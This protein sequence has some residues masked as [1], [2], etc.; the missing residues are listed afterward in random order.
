MSREKAIVFVS[1]L[2][3][4][5]QIICNGIV[6]NL[7]KD[8]DEVILPVTSKTLCSIERMYR[9]LNVTC[10]DGNTDNNVFSIIDKL[11]SEGYNFLKIGM[12]GDR[13]MVDDTPFS[14]S[15][16]DQAGIPFSESFDSFHLIRNAKEEEAL[17]NYYKPSDKYAFLHQD[18]PRGLEV[19][20]DKH[21]PAE[22]LTIVEP[23][24][25]LGKPSSDYCKLIE[26]AEEIHC[27]DSSFALLIDRLP[28]IL[29]QKLFLHRYV[30]WDGPKGNQQGAPTTYRKPWEII[31]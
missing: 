4:G 7:L 21:A 9:G 17:Y 22:G 8:Y 31:L 13:F 1:H 3:L 23:D 20:F 6:V 29:N 30:R 18:S 24:F 15:F 10:V 11:E 26:G 14:E 2:G 5:D 19:S 27:I 28:E 12:W 25:D 16:Y